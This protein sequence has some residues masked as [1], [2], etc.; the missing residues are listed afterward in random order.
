MKEETHECQGSQKW[1]C[2]LGRRIK[3]VRREGGNRTRSLGCL[4]QEI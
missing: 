2:S 3:D 4:H 1:E